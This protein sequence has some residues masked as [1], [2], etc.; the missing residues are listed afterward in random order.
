[1]FFHK[2]WFFSSLKGSYIRLHIFKAKKLWCVWNAYYIGSRNTKIGT[3]STTGHITEK[4]SSFRLLYFVLGCF[5]ISTGWSTTGLSYL[6]IHWM[7]EVTNGE[8]TCKCSMYT[9]ANVWEW[10]LQL[11]YRVKL[12]LIL[13]QWWYSQYNALLRAGCRDEILIFSKTSRPILRPT[14]PLFNGYQGKWTN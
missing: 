8:I 9:V 14:Q 12:H 10:S 3:L 11:Y 4:L 1:M 13:L 7:K 2:R 5:V 6:I